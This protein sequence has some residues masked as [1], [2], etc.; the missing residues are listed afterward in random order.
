MRLFVLC[1]RF[2]CLRCILILSLTITLVFV[3]LVRCCLC[4][5][6]FASQLCLIFNVIYLPHIVTDWAR[7]WRRGN[8]T[9]GW[10]AGWGGVIDVLALWLTVCRRDFFIIGSMPA[11]VS[12]LLCWYSHSECQ[13]LY[14]LCT[15]KKKYRQIAYTFIISKNNWLCLQIICFFI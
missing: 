7:T 6:S 2:L 1:A 11:L 9:K 5:L 3:V 4:R 8:E 15:N 12:L 14:I 13:F 10:A